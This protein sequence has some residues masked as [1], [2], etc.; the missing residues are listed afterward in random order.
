MKLLLGFLA[1]LLFTTSA[2][3]ATVEEDVTRY[4][5]IFSSDASL[6]SDAADTFTWMGLSDARIFDLIEQRLLADANAAANDKAE[7]NRVARYIRSLG[8]SGQAKYL[9]TINKFVTDNAYERYAKAA[10]EDLPNYQRW[11]PIIANR[12]SFDPKLSDDENRVINML[13]A[14]DF[15]LKRVGAKRVFYK[16]QEPAVLDI[17]AQELKANYA[18]ADHN[19]ADA[20]AWMVKALGQPRLAKYKPLIE[21]V[22]ASA[23]EDKVSKHANKVLELYQQ[24][25]AR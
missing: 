14:D 18:K 12:A 2:M 23:R 22:A 15:M 11:N 9:P 4:V 20:I 1:A 16:H 24:K 10:L 21:E 17:L 3:S 19:N 7:K 13:R 25:S 5:R 6:H 8:F